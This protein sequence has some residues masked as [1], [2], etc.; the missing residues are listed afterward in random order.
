M[1]YDKK[2]I[3]PQEIPLEENK[4]DWKEVVKGILFPHTF[5]VFVLFNLTVMGLVFI[6]M[7][8]WHQTILAYIFYAFSFYTLVIVGVRIP[9]L[10]KNI[11]EGLYS[12]KFTHRYMTDKEYRAKFSVYRGLAINLAFAIFKV[13]IGFVYK[14]PWLF[15]MA[16]YQTIMSL[17]RLA[18]VLSERKKVEGEE[19][20]LIRGLKSYHVCSWFMLLLNIAISVIVFM[21][22]FQGQTI[23]YHE[24]MVIGLAAFTFYCFITAVINL[25]KFRRRT[26][27]FYA[28]IKRIDMAKAFVSLFTM[29]V[30]M[31]TAYGQSGTVNVTFLNAMTGVAVCLSILGM[32]VLML[33][34]ISDDYKEGIIH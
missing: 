27:P 23:V 4:K 6:F 3:E 5:L 12:N 32:T 22:V 19:K 10:V 24:I 1:K 13:V 8:N 16:G 34:G 29:Q 14:T 17:M 11:K 20:K 28:A 21:V 15:A 9:R 33:K 30:A 25:G 2:E 7:N 31:L 18:M 26:N